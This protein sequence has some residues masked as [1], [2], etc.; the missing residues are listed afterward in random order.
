LI[1]PKQTHT[2]NL[3]QFI[4][5]ERYGHGIKKHILK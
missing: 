2:H 4:Y 5:S 1:I 3:N